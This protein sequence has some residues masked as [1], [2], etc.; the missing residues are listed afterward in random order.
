MAETQSEEVD[1]GRIAE[2]YRHSVIQSVEHDENH[3]GTWSSE[4]ARG[5]EAL[6]EQYDERSHQL[7]ENEAAA[8]E[9]YD[10]NHCE[11]E[12]GLSSDGYRQQVIE[13]YTHEQMSG[14]A[15]DESQKDDYWSDSSAEASS[16]KQDSVQSENSDYWANDSAANTTDN[17]Q[18]NGLSN[19]A[20][21]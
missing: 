6:R 15:A 5:S 2:D 16:E 10:N 1:R 11:E 17:Q 4:E 7:D 21:C 14:N 8:K 18:E 12:T 13:D 3:P 19:E 20:S 9:Q